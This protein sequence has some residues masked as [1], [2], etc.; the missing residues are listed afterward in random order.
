[1]AN[2]RFHLLVCAPQRDRAALRLDGLALRGGQWPWLHCRAAADLEGRRG[3]QEQW[4]SGAQACGEAGRLHDSK[5]VA[6]KVWR[7]LVRPCVVAALALSGSQDI[8]ALEASPAQARCLWT[9]PKPRRSAH[10]CGKQSRH[11]GWGLGLTGQHVYTKQTHNVSVVCS[12]LQ[13]HLPWKHD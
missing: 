1:M 11:K 4:R 8:L 12:T 13:R 5:S 6:Q 9:W 7:S 10:C 3:S 2:F